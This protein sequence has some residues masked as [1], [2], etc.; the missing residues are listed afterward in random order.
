MFL[1]SFLLFLSSLLCLLQYG[2]G[3]TIH[4]HIFGTMALGPIYLIIL[5]IGV[6]IYLLIK[7]YNK[8]SYY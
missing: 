4:Y 1:R 2:C 3:N 5:L 8:N 7:D 6:I